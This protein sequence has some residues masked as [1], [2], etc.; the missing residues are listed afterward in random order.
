MTPA[1][2]PSDAPGEPGPG[3]VHSLVQLR[4]ERALQRRER[5][6]YVHPLVQAEG[7]GWKVLSANC[8]RTVD[9]QGGVIPIAWLAPT[10]ATGAG[11]WSLHA[12]DHAHGC[13]RL[14]A[15]GLS[16]DEALA[17]LCADPRREFWV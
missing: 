12:R 5:Y 10:A 13:W 17:R 2:R 6:K 15:W 1:L 4:I 14:E 3:Q 8:S 11:L 7:S 16:L 9:R